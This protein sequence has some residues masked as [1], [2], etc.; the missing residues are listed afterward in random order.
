MCN[1]KPIQENKEITD[2]PVQS[3]TEM[4]YAKEADVKYVQLISLMPNLT[5]AFDIPQGPG[6]Q[7][8]KLVRY[9]T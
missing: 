1:A 7:K 2:N 8:S 5:L 3:T 4:G 6:I 9:L